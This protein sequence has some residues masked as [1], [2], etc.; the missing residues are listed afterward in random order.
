MSP[1]SG[2]AN[3]WNR[4]LSATVCYRKPAL[5]P[6]AAANAPRDSLRHQRL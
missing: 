3:S 1:P 4:L 2:Q 6:H 5:S